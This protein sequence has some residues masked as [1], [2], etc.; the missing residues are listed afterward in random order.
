[1]YQTWKKAQKSPENMKNG[2]KNKFGFL[3]LALIALTQNV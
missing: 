3:A 1:M 2:N